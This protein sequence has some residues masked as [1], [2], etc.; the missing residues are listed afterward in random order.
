MYEDIT[1]CSKETKTEAVFKCVPSILES[2]L[3]ILN[4]YG[5]Q[6]RLG[7][8]RSLEIDILFFRPMIR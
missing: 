6:R 5:I 2:W 4:V 3:L 7:Q 1:G 8:R